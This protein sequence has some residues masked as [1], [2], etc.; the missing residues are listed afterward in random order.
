MS[1][2]VYAP[3]E[4]A[5]TEND[6]KNFHSL[7]EGSLDNEARPGEY[8]DIQVFIQASKYPVTNP[9]DVAR[10]MQ[11]LMQFVKEPRD[12][13][14]PVELA[15]RLHLDMAFI[16]PFA[17]GNGRVARLSMNTVSIKH[18]H[19]PTIIAPVLR[20]EYIDCLEKARTNSGPFYEFIFKCVVQT[21][22]DNDTPS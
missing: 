4:K 21:Q 5:L 15:A 8:R 14:H 17:D 7:L 9:K 12:L 20:R 11:T 6:V 1:I 19:L 10:E 3:G 16:H 18:H 2:D 22:K 13:R